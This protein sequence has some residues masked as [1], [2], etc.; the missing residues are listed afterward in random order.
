ML[1]HLTCISDWLMVLTY[2][3][4]PDWAEMVEEAGSLL[5]RQTPSVNGRHLFF[6]GHG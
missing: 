4:R 2:V 1:D 6:G 3:R 5:Q